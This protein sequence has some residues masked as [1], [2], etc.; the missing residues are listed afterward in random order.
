MRKFLV[1]FMVCMLMCVPVAHATVSNSNSRTSLSADGI[2]D[3]FDFTFKIFEDSQVE[4][5]LVE[6]ADE[7]NSLLQT[8]TTDYTVTL[9]SATEGGTVSMVS[10]PSSTFNVT[11]IRDVDYTQPTDLPV[12][13]GFSERTLE[14]AYDRIVMQTQQLKD[15]SD[16]S[17][18]LP[19]SSSTTDI[20]FPSPEDGNVIV[21][22]GT[23]GTTENQIYST[24]ALDAAVTAAQ[25]AETNAETAE[26]NAETAETNAETAETNAETAE[27]N[28]A[29]SAV[30]AALSASSFDGSIYDDD[31]DTGFDTERTTDDDTLRLIVAGTDMATIDA[32][33]FQLTTTI[34]V[35]AIY[36]DDSFAA[37][38][39]VAL[40]TQQSIKAY[41]AANRGVAILTSSDASWD[42]PAGV[43]QLYI[44]MTGG[45]GGGGGGLRIGNNPGWGGGGG[46]GASILNQPYPVTPAQEIAVVVGIGGA[47]GAGGVN[48]SNGTAST[49]DGVF[50]C[51]YG[52]G[53][54][55][56]TETAGNG[57]DGGTIATSLQDTGYTAGAGD[58]PDADNG[59]AG[60]VIIQGYD[61]GAG[62]N[63]H[64]IQDSGGSGGTIFGGGVIGVADGDGNDGVNSGVGGSGGSDTVGGGHTGG[65]GADGIVIIRW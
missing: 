12:N 11:M 45:G 59:D 51:D 4:V 33:G 10:T 48:G 22:V 1:L 54:T 17:V 24:T 14:N 2:V 65:D 61:G 49:F 5:Y 37:D 7:S 27:I 44:T 53:G 32:N 29:A 60:S 35:N 43:T 47:G 9:S 52:N 34:A 16:K 20:E 18:K 57:G 30:A 50:T 42:V 36:D 28:A 26:T 31:G 8:L 15:L 46:A 23:D 38:S 63:A 55:F 19:I 25:L 13:A 21:W 56:G 6:D 39:N 41:I 64:T 40:A 58:A 62:G 3:D